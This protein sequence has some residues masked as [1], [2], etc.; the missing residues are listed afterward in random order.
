MRSQTLSNLRR[1]LG[2]LPRRRLWSLALQVVL[3]V[4]PGVVDLL[5]VAVVA[6]LTGALSGAALYDQLPGI[7]VFGGDR[8][9]QSL[10]LIGVFVLLAWVSSLTKLLLR[11]LQNSVST[12]IWRD[13]SDQ[14]Y[15]RVVRQGYAYHLSRSTPELAA[16][17]LQNYERIASCAVRPVLQMISALVS[18]LLLSVGVLFIGR[19]LAVA[20]VGGLAIAYWVLT[21][22]IT[23]QL[24]HAVRQRLRQERES[25][26]I[27]YESLASIRDIQL[28][29]SEPY[30]Q[31]QFERVGERAKR[32]VVAGELLPDIPRGL[33]EPLG[34]TL[35]F[36]VGAIPALLSGSSQSVAA[37]LPFL[38]TIAVAALRLT[39][40]LQDLFRAMT[41]LRGSLPMVSSALDLLDLPADRPTLRTPG[42]P[43]PAGVFPRNT[44]RLQQISY[45]YPG[46][47]DWVLNDVSLTIPVGSR[48]A[49]VGATGSGKST[50]ANI[51]LGLL[52]PQRGQLELDGIPVEGLDMPAWQAN[53]A[54]VPQT[55]SLLNRTVLEN[56]AFGYSQDQAN[57]DR[58]WEALEAAQLQDFVAELPYGLYTQVGEN[59]LRLSGGQRQRLA[60][61][62]AFYR[63]AR[64]LVLDEAT[65]ALDNRTESEVIEALE[66]IGRR[67]TTVVIAHRLSTVQRCDRIYE[68]ADG[69][70]KAYGSYG[71]LQQRSDSFRELTRLE[72]RSA[73]A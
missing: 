31:G 65:S 63:Q 2:Y 17:I 56:V 28:T 55:I 3:S 23:P 60:L 71:E 37:I 8:P 44:I 70:V 22:L 34:I 11:Y 21:S 47:H 27:L 9:D 41:M 54:Q 61:A 26:E 5:T 64:F 14:A 73:S 13:L 50:T 51:L 39:A 19:W 42:V 35:I 25:N 48:V 46:Q 16:Q 32:Y 1:L 29:S 43:S 20:L 72:D 6:R 7:H 66:V 62:R 15:A 49:L 4:V 10:W 18:I 69:R 67:C 68:F 52:Q 36:V 12:E 59:G 45:R 38:A 53:C 40:P 58:V 57:Q 30:F 24:R 33:I